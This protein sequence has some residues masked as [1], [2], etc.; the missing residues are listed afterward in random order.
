M[1]LNQELSKK[2]ACLIEHIN[3]NY[4]KEP[5]FGIGLNAGFCVGVG[6]ASQLTLN[7]SGND[8]W[9]QISEYLYHNRGRW[10]A[11]YI[12][13]DILNKEGMASHHNSTPSV[14]L[15]SPDT[16]YEVNNSSIAYSLLGKLK[17]IRLS[18]LNFKQFELKPVVSLADFDTDSDDEYLSC[19][20]KAHD[21]VIQDQE[22]RR[23]MTVSRRID[24]KM[25]FDLVQSIV[26]FRNEPE[27]SIPCYWRSDRIEFA[28]V[29]PERTFY[30]ES[31]LDIFHCQKVS[32]TFA[33][34][35]NP[36]QDRAL[37]QSFLSDT[38]NN[39]EHDISV[40]SL[41]DCVHEIGEISNRRKELLDMP[42]IRH[43]LTSFDV[44]LHKDKNVIDICRAVFPKGVQP[45]EDGLKILFQFEPN[46]R[47]P[48]YGMF[49]VQTPSG[50]V[51]GAHIIRMIFH[52]N[53]LGAYY[54][55]CGA[56][57]TSGSDLMDEYKETQLKLGSIV[58]R[59]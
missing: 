26:P 13:Y 33:R 8:T 1:V 12:G 44:L 47:G 30:K 2:A 28:G 57:I 11:G 27:T 3:T 58:A 4:P 18:S 22:Y 16:V 53:A 42:N 5:V 15:I 32:G 38:K 49:F 46:N 25:P 50:I 48:Y 45:I 6:V 40:A 54:T 24:F 19:V 31:G 37:M 59:M 20:G 34:D 43:F 35:K 55:H 21:W 36:S 39:N 41:I 9:Q 17:P 7:Q 51:L 56:C 52:D 29:S 23:R 14:H 10:V